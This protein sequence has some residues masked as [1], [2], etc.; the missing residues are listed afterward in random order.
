ML[1]PKSFPPDNFDRPQRADSGACQPDFAVTAVADFFQ[2]FVIGDSGTGVSP[3]SGSVA[4]A[5][6]ACVRFARR[7]ACPIIR[8]GTY[9]QRSPLFRKVVRHGE[10]NL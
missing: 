2:G 6:K 4:P 7:D 3:V 1:V 9:V 8:N 10:P 5:V